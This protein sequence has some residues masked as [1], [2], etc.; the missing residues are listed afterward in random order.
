MLDQLEQITCCS[1]Q[2]AK[3]LDVHCVLLNRIFWHKAERGK[4]STFFSLVCLE[5]QCSVEVC[6]ANLVPDSFSVKARTPAQN[7]SVVMVF[8]LQSCSRTFL[9]KRS[10]LCRHV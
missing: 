6:E 9:K 8:I 5:Y 10:L 1:A 7:F 2:T 3:A 4:Q